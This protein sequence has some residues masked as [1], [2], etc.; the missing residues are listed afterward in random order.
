MRSL[1]LSP[2]TIFETSTVRDNSLSVGGIDYPARK[3]FGLTF[4]G[5]VAPILVSAMV[6][7]S[8]PTLGTLALFLSP[9]RQDR[10]LVLYE[11]LFN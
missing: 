4:E 1:G 8:H 2:D 9:F 6:E 3:A 7:L 11:A 5:P 10:E